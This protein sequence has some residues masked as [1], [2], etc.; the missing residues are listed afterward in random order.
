MK[1]YVLYNCSKKHFLLFFITFFAWQIVQS[2]TTAGVLW[3][4]Q[5]GGK[6]TE[7][8]K[9]M[10]TDS[11]GNIYF[12][13]SFR[14][15][16][17]F[18]GINLT[19]DEPTAEF[20]VKTNSSGDVLWAKKFGGV[21]GYNGLRGITM[22]NAGYIY[23]MGVFS[24]TSTFDDI[25]LNA[26]S[27]GYSQ[28]T[29]VVKQDPSGDVIWATT[30]ANTQSF[31]YHRP[32]SIVADTQ[33]NIYIT[34]TFSNESITFGD[35]TLTRTTQEEKENLFITKQDNQGN[36]LWAKN[37]NQTGYINVEKI[38]TDA[39][40]NVYIIGS[41]NDT[42]EFGDNVF[43]NSDQKS[44]FFVVKLDP[45]GETIWAKH[46]EI[47]NSTSSDSYVRDFTID[48]TGNIY[49]TGIF[50]GTLKAGTTTL[51]AP[52]INDRNLFI[53]KTDNL[54]NT[55]WGKSFGDN[56][57]LFPVIYMQIHQKIYM[58]QVQLMVMFGLM[59]FF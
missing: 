25:T 55:L 3:A 16:T 21:N 22:D 18:G 6:E 42:V 24:G 28:N 30:L 7:I 20:V 45:L 26:N 54:G 41:F 49:I 1:N 19:T 32:V 8:P 2:Q 10:V 29:Y 37:F 50:R 46:F 12:T 48:E 11:Y 17:N 36:I 23:T 14:K 4:K 52:N 35:F 53:I 51:T 39:S 15:E 40:N 13:G 43:T 9:N 47:I 27:S 56:K 33:N 34:G 44:D 5:Y 38:I 59:I 31:N 57:K 58:L